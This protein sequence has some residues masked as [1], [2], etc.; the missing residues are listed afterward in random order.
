LETEIEKGERR[1]RFLLRKE[2]KDRHV[3][4]KHRGE[5]RGKKV[6]E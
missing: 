1:E 2:G 6:F 4:V 3:F 5:Q